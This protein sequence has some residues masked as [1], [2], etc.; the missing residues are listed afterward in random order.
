MDNFTL[1]NRTALVAK[2]NSGK[3]VLLSQLVKAEKKKFDKI[4]VVSPT[5]KINKFYTKQKIADE[6]Y[7]ID[8][9]SEEYFDQ[10]IKKMTEIN[11]DKTDKQKKKILI[12]LD[13]ALSDINAHSSKTLKQIATRGRHIGIYLII[14]CQYLHMIPPAIRTQIDY[15]FCGQMNKNSVNILCDE[16]QSSNIS[17]EDFVQC[18]NRCTKDYSF[19]VINNNSCKT[20]DL[21]EN[22]GMIK[23][24]F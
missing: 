15:I 18:Y 2:T 21:N 1:L 11:T 8:E 13:D 12:I 17:K 9:Y 3:S 7:I 16:Y 20:N 4:I 5:E 23:A 14:T 22:Y 6:K 19:M 24:S 10:L